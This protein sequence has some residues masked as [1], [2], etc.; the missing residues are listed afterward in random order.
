METDF[1]LRKGEAINILRSSG[2]TILDQEGILFASLHHYTVNQN[3]KG[4][5]DETPSPSHG[6]SQKILA[7][8]HIK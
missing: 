5:Q 7:M 8:G 3:E 4:K 6:R 1:F 2:Q